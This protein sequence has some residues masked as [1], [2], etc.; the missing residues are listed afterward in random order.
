M[1]VF[2]FGCMGVRGRVGEWVGGRVWGRGKGEC[3]DGAGRGRFGGGMWFGLRAGRMERGGGDAVKQRPM[4]G[5]VSKRRLIEV[6]RDLA[7]ENADFA[8]L[9][10]APLTS[11]AHSEA[12]GEWHAWVA[13]LAR[14]RRAHPSL[15]SQLSLEPTDAEARA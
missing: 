6:V 7:M 9:A 10:A 8:A 15:A 5:S 2:F 11:F 14:I 12:K 13:A 3:E 1:C 4:P